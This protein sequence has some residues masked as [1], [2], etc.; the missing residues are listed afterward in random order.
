MTT[1][2]THR[3]IVR[4]GS[5]SSVEIRPTPSPGPGELLLAPEAV[6]LCGTDIQIVRGDR[7]DPSPIV[8]HEGAARVVEL[9]E[10]V[11]EF[12]VGDRVVVNP[13]HP[14]DSSF[15]LG[16][17]VEG[18]FQE[19]VVIGASAVSSGL[20]SLLPDDLSSVRATLV[21][22]YAVVR[23][24][25][26]CLARETP[27]TL[28]IFGDGL[29]GNLAATLAPSAMFPTVEVAMV[30]RTELGAKW[31]A[32]YLPSVQNFSSGDDW[33]RHITG[34]VA[35]L[36]ATHRAGTV[37]SI[38]EAIRRLGDRVVAVHPIGGV[39]AKATSGLLPGVDIAGVRQANTGGPTP[40]AVTTFSRGAQRVAF[41]GNRGVTNDQLTAAATALTAADDAIDGLLTHRRDIVEGTALMN[42]ICEQRTRVV[43]GELVMRL[44]VGLG[45]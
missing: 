19:R 30:H 4:H 15:L 41:T 33:E 13:T 27:Q 38:D 20:V 40:P 11:S 8:G 25:L 28:L 12:A 37:A 43:D 18:L 9:G 31:T 44:V 32:N 17:N 34:S 1:E 24:A 45:A 36:G 14:H 5:H 6:S 3:A 42:T 39:P 2:L 21:E 7:N 10:G 35:V 23:Y 26:S 29:I 22:P 16:H